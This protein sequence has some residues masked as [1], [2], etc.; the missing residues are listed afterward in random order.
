MNQ[1]IQTS[2]APTYDVTLPRRKHTEKPKPD[3]SSLYMQLPINC[4]YRGQKNMVNGTTRMQL[5]MFSIWK[6]HRTNE[7]VSITNNLQRGKK[8]EEKPID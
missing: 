1:W 3:L 5:V 8:W 7:C 4:K 6:L 2:W